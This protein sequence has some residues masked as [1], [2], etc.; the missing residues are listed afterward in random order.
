M[1]YQLAAPG[2]V[3]VPGYPRLALRG[4]D[5]RGVFRVDGE[6]RRVCVA[7]G[8]L[9]VSEWARIE[10]SPWE[11]RKPAG[12]GPV[13][14]RVIEG[15]RYQLWVR[16]TLVVPPLARRGDNGSWWTF[17]PDG[18]RLEDAPVL[19]PLSGDPCSIQDD[20]SGYICTEDVGHLGDHIASLRCLD[21]RRAIARWPA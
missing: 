20:R 1:E 17:G 6:P 10:G 11:V 19:P 3:V 16:E 8:D 2:E 7:D 18:A 5:E 21:H 13:Y 9:P 14:A 4:H 15:E 12:E